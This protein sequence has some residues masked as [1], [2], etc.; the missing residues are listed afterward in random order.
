MVKVEITA[1]QL[2][3]EGPFGAICRHYG[4]DALQGQGAGSGKV[5]VLQDGLVIGHIPVL[6]DGTLVD[7]SFDAE[8]P[9]IFVSFNEMVR[10]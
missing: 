5:N 1:E 2:I 3:T 9:A 8:Q 7:V 6:A 10:V 4:A